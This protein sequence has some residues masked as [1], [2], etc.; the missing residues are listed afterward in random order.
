MVAVLKVAEVVEGPG[1]AG[2]VC[3]VAHSC[4]ECDNA[5]AQ[6]IAQARMRRWQ[7]AVAPLVVALAVAS[8][9][10]RQTHSRINVRVVGCRH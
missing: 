9:R 4:V 3:P 8:I 7:I 10:I 5:Q 1:L 2:A 6:L